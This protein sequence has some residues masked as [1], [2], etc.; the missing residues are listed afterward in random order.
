VEWAVDA[1]IAAGQI[2]LKAAL[3]QFLA[4]VSKAQPAGAKARRH[5]EHVRRIQPGDIACNQR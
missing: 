2:A 5:L 4:V 3:L 1:G